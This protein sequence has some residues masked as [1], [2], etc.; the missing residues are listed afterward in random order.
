[1]VLYFS[2]AAADIHPSSLLIMQKFDQVLLLFSNISVNINEINSKQ[3]KYMFKF[4]MRIAHIP[5]TLRNYMYWE[6]WQIFFTIRM[7]LSVMSRY[8]GAEHEL[9]E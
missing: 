5:H 1:M 6:T 8:L 7:L 4:A 3:S 9:P 2:A